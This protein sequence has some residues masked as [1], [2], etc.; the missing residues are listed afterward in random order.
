MF[1]DHFIEEWYKNLHHFH[2]AQNLICELIHKVG[3]NWS[4]NHFIVWIWKIGTGA[5]INYQ[6]K[7]IYFVLNQHVCNVLWFDVIRQTSKYYGT[8]LQMPLPFNHKN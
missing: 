2:Q 5:A 8:F 3:Y 7:N 4:D 6:A 1:A